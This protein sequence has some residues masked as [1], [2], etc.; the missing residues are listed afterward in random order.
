MEW[1]WIKPSQVLKFV[2]PFKKNLY[3]NILNEF[4]FLLRVIKFTYI[5]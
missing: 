5:F 4:K 3:E 1:K 2:V